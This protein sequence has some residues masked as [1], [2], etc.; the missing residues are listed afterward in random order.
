M[1]LPSEVSFKEFHADRVRKV[2]I[3]LPLEYALSG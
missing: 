2:W 3:N 1:V